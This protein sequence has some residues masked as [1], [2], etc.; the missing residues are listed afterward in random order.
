MSDDKKRLRSDGNTKYSCHKQKGPLSGET[1]ARVMAELS[2]SK[3]KNGAGRGPFLC[4]R[5]CDRRRVGRFRA[6]PSRAVTAALTITGR[7]RAL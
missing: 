1:G 7:A 2:E 6:S 5:G 3:T 4:R